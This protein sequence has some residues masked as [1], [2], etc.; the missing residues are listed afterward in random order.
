[1]RTRYGHRRSGDRRASAPVAWLAR[2][3]L[4]RSGGRRQSR[5]CELRDCLWFCGGPLTRGRLL[6][7]VAFSSSVV[8]GRPHLMRGQASGQPIVHL[9]T[10]VLCAA[11]SHISQPSSCGSAH[12]ALERQRRIAA[13][14]RRS[15]YLLTGSLDA[16][17]PATMLSTS[18][19]STMCAHF[20]ST[21]GRLSR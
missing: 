13:R 8:F 20:V 2:F 18:Y 17:R 14:A 21:R 11:C 10:S 16:Q 12:Q 4:A 3:S 7:R 6:F 1:M 19:S 15:C 9:R 5:T